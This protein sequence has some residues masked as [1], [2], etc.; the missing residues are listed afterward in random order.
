MEYLSYWKILGISATT[1]KKMIK[2]AYAQK[3]K[4]YHPEQHPEQFKQLQNAYKSALLY[5]KKTTNENQSQYEKELNAYKY[6]SILENDKSSIGIDLKNQEI[7]KSLD[8]GIDSVKVSVEINSSNKKVKSNINDIN[9]EYEKHKKVKTKQTDVELS[10]VEIYSNT[11][12]K[13]VKSNIEDIIIE[14][15]KHKKVKTKQT[16]VELND[17]EIDFNTSE[18]KVK[19]N[20]NDINI[21]SIDIGSSN[22]DN[23][24]KKTEDEYLLDKL[25]KML[26]FKMDIN[27]LNV[28]LTNERVLYW[29]KN[30]KFK[31][32]IEEILIRK[33]D[34]MNQDIKNYLLEVSSL[35]GL[36]RVNLILKKKTIKSFRNF[37]IK[38]A[39][40]FV[41]IILF[42]IFSII[43]NKARIEIENENKQQLDESR[44]SFF[45]SLEE[46]VN[47]DFVGSSELDEVRKRAKQEE[48]MRKLNEL[49]SPYLFGV[50][51][52]LET[53][54][55]MLY[56]QEKQL[57]P[58][59]YQEIYFTTTNHLLLKNEGVVEVFNCSEKTLLPIVYLDGYILDVSFDN[60][61]YKCVVVS[62]ESHTWLFDPSENQIVID[63]FGID[64]TTQ[65]I[66]M[67]DGEITSVR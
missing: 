56:D 26:A 7:S 13:K 31:N 24:T 23:E 49:N 39:L 4:Q 55:Y 41:G 44:E 14:Y 57:L 18:N 5:A 50:K 8:S 40:I 46:R 52:A 10:D 17:V 62:N 20:I 43:N 48:E 25:K 59:N 30:D 29:L 66:Y 9:I 53:D 28:F 61:L 6:D 12:E 65:M 27:I 35:L 47:Q 34:Q 3:A 11:L 36:D 42:I 22:I 32:E 63:S 38:I 54:G 58:T 60:A 33:L 64:N 1:D 51:V 16:D 19:S 37:K 15:D 21:A 2:K 67:K 45:D